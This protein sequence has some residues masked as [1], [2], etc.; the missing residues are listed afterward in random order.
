MLG[1]QWDF[2]SDAAVLEMLRQNKDEQHELQRRLSVWC[3]TL[4]SCFFD[5]LAVIASSSLLFAHPMSAWDSGQRRWA[6]I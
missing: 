6:G 4:V 2:T 5:W 3:P 1:V